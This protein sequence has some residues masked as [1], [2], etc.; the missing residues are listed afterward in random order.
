ML[1]NA[2]MGDLKLSQCCPGAYAPSNSVYIHIS[3]SS[4]VKRVLIGFSLYVTTPTKSYIDHA[5]QRVR[6]G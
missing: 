3:S 5:G 1:I 4:E 6:L 2:H